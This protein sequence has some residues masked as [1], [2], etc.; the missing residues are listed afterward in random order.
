MQRAPVHEC[1]SYTCDQCEDT[2]LCS[3]SELTA[4]WK[5]TRYA[6]GKL[7]L[8]PDCQPSRLGKAS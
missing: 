1:N 2:V 8:C 6:N 5:W 3:L 7:L 4:V